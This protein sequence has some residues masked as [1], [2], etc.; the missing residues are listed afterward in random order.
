MV[1]ELFRHPV[2]LS[3]IVPVGSRAAD[4]AE[5]YAE[6]R[7]GLDALGRSY[8]MIFVLDGPHETFAAGLKQ[9][10]AGDAIGHGRRA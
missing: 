4:P 7:A 8:E 1:A 9:L 6:Y 2:D 3:V 5:L 10:D